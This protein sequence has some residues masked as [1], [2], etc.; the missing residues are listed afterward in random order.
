M[1]GCGTSLVPLHPL[2]LHNTTV[3]SRNGDI[4][5][6][7]THGLYNIH[8]SKTIHVMSRIYSI[9]GL[10]VHSLGPYVLHHSHLQ[11]GGRVS[12]WTFK[13]MYKEAYT[14][15]H[16]G[17]EHHDIPWN[18]YDALLARWSLLP[19]W[20]VFPDTHTPIKDMQTGFTMLA[21]EWNHN[22]PRKLSMG[23]F[24]TRYDLHTDSCFAIG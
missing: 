20:N 7:S 12:S 14:M 17:K 5:Q 11:S 1:F 24:W 16:K 9:S 18:T 3:K 8:L 21:D 13:F 2:K 4:Y 23:N 22:L 10:D 6:I 19:K 15:K